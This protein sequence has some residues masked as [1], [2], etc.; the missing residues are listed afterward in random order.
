MDARNIDGSTPLCD[1][2]AAG[3]LDCVKLLLEYGA[4]VNPPLFTFTP[5][6]E[7]C[8]A[9]IYCY[10]PSNTGIYVES[11]IQMFAGGKSG[12]TFKVSDNS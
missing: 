9:G 5:L 1:A 4:S 6:H 2:C 7:A 3:S 8:M 10:I 12:K 11:H